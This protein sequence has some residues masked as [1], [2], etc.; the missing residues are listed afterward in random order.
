MRE[1]IFTKGFRKQYRR[2]SKKVQ[3]QFDARYQ[4]WY[5]DPADPTLRVHRLK[6][7]MSK[8]HSFNV[9]GDIRALY[10]VVDDKIYI[11]EVI[12]SHSELYG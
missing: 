1:V 7:V 2:Q 10:E 3:Q 6:G 12:G 8:Y 9:T 4:L 5:D 11:F